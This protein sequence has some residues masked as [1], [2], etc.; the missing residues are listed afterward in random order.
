[1][2][3]KFYNSPAVFLEEQRPFFEKDQV[4]NHLMYGLSI[5]AA[6]RPSN[7]E[8]VLFATPAD[9]YPK[10]VG[11]QSPGRHL[12]L[13]AES[14]FSANYLPL[15]EGLHTIKEEI[16]EL[17]ASVE[18]ALHFATAWAQVHQTAYTVSLRQL[19]YELR[20][21]P[22]LTYP[23]GNFRKA[24]MDDL[25]V[26]ADWIYQFNREADIGDSTPDQ[27]LMVAHRRIEVGELFVWETNEPVSLAGSA[28]PTPKGVAVN[29]V[30]T[31]PEFRGRGYASACV[32]SLSRRLLEKG[33]EFCTLFTDL[34]YPTSNKIYRQIGYRPVSEFRTIQ[35]QPL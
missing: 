7:D 8:L 4:V 24:S 16:T 18:T 25:D 19:V 14:G 9:Y 12:I 32:A 34:D 28:R 5:R 6:E 15:A 23:Q 35:F 27:A 1:M 10:T 31:P 33:F 30:Y 21:I 17:V 29:A 22:S 2:K 26:I 20:S 13:A 3:L 11:F